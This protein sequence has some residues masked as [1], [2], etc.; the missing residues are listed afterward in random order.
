[1]ARQHRGDAI[2]AGAAHQIDQKGLGL[3]VGSVTGHR[4]WPEH[5]VP[6]PTGS[7]L[8]IATRGNTDLLGPEGGAESIGD[9]PHDLR[10]A[11]CVGSHPVVD[12]HGRDIESG[13][14]GEDEESGGIGSAG[15]GTDN[16][17]ARR[18]E[19]AAIE[20]RGHDGIAEHGLGQEPVDAVMRLIH[21]SGSRISSMAG[22]ASGPVHT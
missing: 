18:R 14:H 4:V 11:R 16:R 8:E 12:V 1:M 2:E 20:Q 3:V 5:G 10:L 6:G 13:G 21:S 19:V 15:N 22:S 7:R 9:G 17:G